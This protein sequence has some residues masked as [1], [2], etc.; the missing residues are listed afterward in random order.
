MKS[1]A[2]SAVAL[3]SL[4]NGSRIVYRD[5][6]TTTSAT[7]TPTEPCAIVSA[8]WS[9]QISATA[10][11]IVEAS[12]AYECLN[13]VPINKDAALRFID[14][15]AP[16]IEWQSDTVFLKIPPADYFYP[17]T[18]L[19]ATLDRIR[20]DL[21]A[22]KYSNE[23]EWQEDL[24]KNFFGPAHDGHL[25]VYPDA[26]S[27]AIE[28]Q[29]PYALVSISEEGPAGSAPVIK[30][31]DDVVAGIENASVVKLING[32]DASTFIGD[33]IYQ[34]SSNQ[35]ADAAY[36]SAFFEKAS[37]LNKNTGYFQNG[38]RPR[39]VFP[40]NATSFT[41]ENGTEVVLPNQAR[42][43]SSW[44]GVVD[45]PS[46][47]KKFCSG[48][49]LNLSSVAS[50]PATT[51]S[52]PTSSASATAA[53]TSS[54]PGYPEPLV[55]S[56]DQVISGYYIDEPGFEDVA[57]ISMLSFSS[58]PVD[59]Q[60]VAQTFYAQAKKDGKTKL[61]VDVQANGGGFIFLGYDGFRQL[62][63]D[64]VQEGLGR[65]RNHDGFD[66]ISR[67]FSDISADFDPDTASSD[68][69]LA[70]ESVFNWRYDINETD[71]NFV[72]YEDK[73][74][75]H[76]FGG[77]NYTSLI[78]WNFTDALSTSNETYG[79]GTDITGYGSRKN[80]TR[81]FGGPE[82]IVLLYDGYCASTCT[83]FSEFL[84]SNAGVKSIA[85]GGRPTKEGLIQGVGG[86]KGS[87]SYEFS[88]ITSQAQQARNYTTDPSI[89][90]TL[91]K[92]TS[93]V[94]V[95]STAASLNVKDQI[96]PGNLED[97]IPAQFVTEESDC[98]LWWTAPMITDI[99][100]LWKAAATAAFKGGKCAYGAI[101]YPTNATT[102]AAT[103]PKPFGKSSSSTSSTKTPTKIGT[104]T[105]SKQQAT[106][107]KSQAFMAS[108]HMHVVD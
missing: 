39:Y 87:Q 53:A 9:S 58:D 99:T 40:G 31:Y 107:Q 26:L 86:V 83:L 103:G 60:N 45:G 23:Y 69:I 98:R 97:G 2:V 80:F 82:N 29:R 71:G 81:P 24:Y 96:L 91:D 4:A 66:A 47:F 75:P 51:T 7:P 84:R 25:V 13:S 63:P 28:W 3:A 17:P 35:D 54:V 79:L 50:T 61:V 32:V 92:Y 67:V 48:A 72:S 77:D 44:N 16:Y 1:S 27:A 6:N 95:R 102:K 14:E 100:E 49:N 37:V 11:P 59:F 85:M 78:Q 90:A 68:V 70:A 33:W 64:I 8:S 18:D 5:T 19:W 94:S 108:Q 38:G 52:E 56:R 105:Q 73:F 21:E 43:K 106:L 30:V 65:W 10:T 42:V 104:L 22:D 57:V 88:D 15:L 101:D 93:Y 55:I 41:F 76:E 74:G 36:N 62:F 20:A 46:F 89:L 12:I 34:V